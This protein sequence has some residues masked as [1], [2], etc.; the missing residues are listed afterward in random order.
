MAVPLSQRLGLVLALGL[1][2]R[3]LK[4]HFK[5]V[6]HAKRRVGDGF[7]PFYRADGLVAAIAGVGA[8]HA[9]CAAEILLDRDHVTGVVCAGLAGAL[10]QELTT[11]D[12]VVASHTLTLPASPDERPA[13]YASNSTWHDLALGLGAEGQRVFSGRVLTSE[14]VITRAAEKRR[15]AGAYGAMAVDMESAGVA[16]A[17]HARG[18]PFLA[19]RAVSD[20]ARTD[21][22]EVV[23]EWASAGGRMVP[24]PREVAGLVRLGLHARSAAKQLA[25]FVTRFVH[26]VLASDTP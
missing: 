7:V 11:G 26:A 9:A 16:T 13:S 3:P 4:R 21:M 19:V 25:G 24:S 10:S 14:R 20:D 8:R 17:A 5:F 6:R 12:I 22:P 2:F 1:E 15:L 23:D 18:R